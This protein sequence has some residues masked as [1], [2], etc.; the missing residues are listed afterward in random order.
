[1]E[2]RTYGKTGMQVSVLGFGGAEIGYGHASL[3]DVKNL[4]H[5]ALEQGLTMIDT[6]A[7]YAISEERIGE[8]ISDRRK[9]YY[10]FT[11][12][13]HASG[14]DLPDWS[15]QLITQS[16]ERS[17]Q[18]L[19]TD[20]VDVV[21]LH[22]CSKE[23]LQQGEVI[24]ALQKAKQE[25]KTRFIGYSGDG[26]VAKY[27]VEM[28]VFDSLET[29]IN[30]ADQEAIELTLPTAVKQGMGII[31]KRPIANAAWLFSKDTVNEYSRP[32]YDRLQ[33][34]QYDFLKSSAQDAVATALRFTLKVPGVCTAIVGTKNP[35]RYEENASMILGEPMSDEQFHTIRSRFQA[36][37]DATW[38][39]QI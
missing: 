28:G 6:A 16:I 30:I 23:I 35:Q 33:T 8:A 25:G 3:T 24:E 37:A 20:Y 9:D 12:C 34:L 2:K 19:R 39:G 36:V 13:G 26:Q 5:K 17:L 7:C 4:L 29:S 21:H 15:P 38:V 22:S 18:R 27:A 14:L 32:Y 11:K 1:M 10:L 31:A